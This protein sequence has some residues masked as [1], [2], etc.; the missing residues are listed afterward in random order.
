MNQDAITETVE[1]LRDAFTY[2]TPHSL[3]GNV[4]K[5]LE[6]ILA[7]E[8]TSTARAIVSLLE[9]EAGAHKMTQAPEFVGFLAGRIEREFCS[10][11]RQDVPDET[12]DLGTEAGALNAILNKARRAGFSVEEVCDAILGLFRSSGPADGDDLAEVVESIEVDYVVPLRLLALSSWLGQL[13]PESAGSAVETQARAAAGVL[14]TKII[15]CGMRVN[16]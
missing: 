1:L 2:S 6:G 4:K 13:K 3:P 5:I 14:A 9:L 16:Q 10:V 12:A 11:P 8:T 7:A 15:G